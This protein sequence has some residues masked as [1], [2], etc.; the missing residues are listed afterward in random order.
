MG[1]RFFATVAAVVVAVLAVAAACRPSERRNALDDS[2]QSGRPGAGEKPES[3]ESSAPSLPVAT[4]KGSAGWTLV[5]TVR[6]GLQHP[7]SVRYDSTLD[8]YF[9]SNINGDAGTA[10]GNGFISRVKPDGAMDSLHF[11]AGGRNGVTLNSPLGLAIL[12][13]TLWVADINTLRA[14]DKHTGAHL[15]DA[16]L[17]SMGAKFL[18]DVCIGHDG[19]VYVTDMGLERDSAG[20]LTHTGTDHIFR[21]AGLRGVGQGWNARDV[22]RGV[23]LEGPNGITWNRLRGHY[24][25][26]PFLGSK[27]FSWMPGEDPRV[28]ATGPG[29]FDGVEVLRDG[30]VLVTSWTDSSLMELRGDSLRTVITELPQPA[31]IGLDTRR[32]QVAIPLSGNNEVVIFTIPEI[33]AGRKVPSKVMR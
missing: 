6:S 12:G 29:A 19:A 27:I 33:T 24:V 21:V 5:S 32:R 26:V 10:D 8:V 20:Q 28:I 7:E 13:D 23:S 18:N 25:V 2:A 3:A 31:D 1:F 4:P 11:I 14:F 15:A 30:R 22:A 16:E 9:I 17:A